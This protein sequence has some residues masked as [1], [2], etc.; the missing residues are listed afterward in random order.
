[1]SRT[2]LWLRRKWVKLI[3]EFGG[4]CQS[5]AGTEELEFAHV[6]PTGLKG[7]GRGKFHRYYDVLRHRRS[8]I[9]LCMTCHD[10]LDGRR[11]RQRQSEYVGF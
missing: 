7:N 5:C 1:M 11:P 3:E 9:L 2:S 8:Y 4:V 6:K 10:E